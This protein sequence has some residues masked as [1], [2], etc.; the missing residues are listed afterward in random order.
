M[1]ISYKNYYLISLNLIFFLTLLLW[2]PTLTTQANNPTTFTVTSPLDATDNNIGDGLCTTNLPATPCTLRAAIQESNANPGHDT[3]LLAATTYTLTITGFGENEAATGDLDISDHLTIIGAGQDLTIID[4]D[5][6]DRIF[7]IHNPGTTFPYPTQP[8]LTNQQ[9][10]DIVVNL[11]HLTLTRGSGYSAPGGSA[12]LQYNG[13]T[14]L[15]HVHITHNVGQRSAIKNEG[16]LTITHS[17]IDHNNSTGITNNAGASTYISATTIAHHQSSA[18]YNQSGYIH[19]THA[20]LLANARA[21]YGSNITIDHS[22]IAY[23]TNGITSHNHLLVTNSTIAYNQYRAIDTY[24]PAYFH[25]NTIVHN[26]TGIDSYGTYSNNIIAHNETNCTND[27]MD[28][29]GYNL[30]DNDDCQTLSLPTDYTQTDP[31]LGDL[32]TNSPR[33]FFP[34][35]TGSP[36]I[37]HADCAQNTL[38]DDQRNTPRPQGHACDIGAYEY[39]G[40]PFIITHADAY[41]FTQGNTLTISPPG[42]LHNDTYHTITPP[43]LR[44]ITQP[45]VGTLTT[46]ATGGF[47]FTPPPTFSGLLT[48]TYELTSADLSDQATAQLTIQPPKCWATFN[49]GTTTYIS[50]NA[51][52]INLAISDAPPHATIKIAGHCAGIQQQPGTNIYQTIQLYQPV[53]LQGGYTHTNWLQPNPIYTTTIDAQGMGRLISINNVPTTFA[54]LNLIN[55][56][57]INGHAPAV[58]HSPND[59]TLLNSTI[60]SN[61]GNL[62]DIQNGSLTMSQTHLYNN[63]GATTQAIK[64]NNASWFIDNSTIRHNDYN[65]LLSATNSPGHITHTTFLSNSGGL[66]QIGAPFTIRHTLFQDNTHI[67]LI[68]YEDH[69]YLTLEYS[70]FISNNQALAGHSHTTINHSYFHGRQHGTGIVYF[71]NFNLFNSTITNYAAGITDSGYHSATSHINNNTI[72]GNIEFGL[73]LQSGYHHLEHNT[74]ANNGTNLW[75]DRAAAAFFVLDNNILAQ[76]TN[77]NCS[78]V[79]IHRSSYNLSDDNSCPLGGPQDLNNADP[80]LA[81]LQDN[82]GQTPTHALLPGSPAVGTAVCNTLFNHDQRGIP[83]PQGALCDRGAYEYNQTPFLHTSGQTYPL[84]QN[85]SLSVPAT[86]RHTATPHHGHNLQFHIIAPP[87]HGTISFQPDGAFTYTPHPA[88]AGTDQFTYRATIDEGLAATATITLDIRPP[89]CWAL[90]TGWTNPI[91]THD[92]TAIQIAARQAPANSQIKVAGHCN[93]ATFYNHQYQLLYIDKPLTVIGGYTLTNW[94]TPTTFTTFDAQQ[95]GPVIY[96]TPN[97]TVT[98]KNLIITGGH[99]PYDYHG[100]GIF[101]GTNS[102]LTVINSHITN[103]HSIIH[104]DQRGGG[105]NNL[106][107]LY[108]I[109]TTIK[110]NYPFGI[111]SD[112]SYGG[113]IPP[114]TIDLQRTAVTHNLGD[115]IHARYITFNIRHSDISYNHGIGVFGGTG[116]SLYNEIHHNQDSGIVGAGL[117]EANNIHHNNNTGIISTRDMVIRNSTVHHNN[118]RY[119]GGISQCAFDPRARVPTWPAMYILNTTISHNTSQTSGGGIYNCDGYNTRNQIFISHSTIAYN[120]SQSTGDGI[121]SYQADVN[122]QYTIIAHN[123]TVNCTQT[124]SY[125]DMTASGYSISTDD[126]CPQHPTDQITD[127]LLGPLR[128]NHG[129]YTPYTPAPT[130]ALLPGSPAVNQIP[131]TATNCRHDFAT[132]QRG[133]AR[134][135]G[136]TCDIGAYQSQQWLLHAPI[137]TYA[138]TYVEAA[139]AYVPL[140]VD[141]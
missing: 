130:H 34:L 110:N 111:Y 40:S 102:H 73:Y 23:N 62:I 90:R 8:S 3:I 81:P 54:N 86:D 24:R 116:Q 57:V 25:H 100:D 79:P 53:T 35:L 58:I 127:P 39:D 64:L 78:A 31:L 59:V 2:L 84:T 80:L 92:A 131:I 88:F 107:V 99:N 122:F 139:T 11:S 109:D 68:E 41:T 49:N 16:I 26:G 47:T 120:D 52:A 123:G 141:G 95:T 55:G 4:A 21:V 22:F 27:N 9:G 32:Q 48:F 72:S 17:L 85:R 89:Q 97:N 104:T 124:G 19:I 101:N 108:T 61:T 117:V 29:L 14:T 70:R 71:S 121:Y 56:A 93:Q 140:I 44:I 5:H 114:R 43:A 15:D 87:T 91:G 138:V 105:I 13:K 118:G 33:P 113:N 66:E 42:L 112:G 20:N 69:A 10:E 7:Q 126:S 83:L 18:I 134:D 12:I 45:A 135:H 96:I 67:P 115:G 6:I 128:N 129:P 106:G 136:P 98:L 65:L 37:N 75:L 76:A 77:A 28:S 51:D 50:A 94:L 103:N 46:T 74:F 132:D 60:H 36:A 38:T 82:G 119:G 137:V 63:T 30:V 1:S 125:G 133:V